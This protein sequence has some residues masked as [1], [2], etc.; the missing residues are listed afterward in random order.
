MPY[1]IS[2]VVYCRHGAHLTLVG[3]NELY[4]RNEPVK[5]RDDPLGYPALLNVSQIEAPGRSRAWICTQYLH[6]DP[7]LPWDAQLA[8]LLNHTWNGAF[9]L[10][11]E[12]HEGASWYGVSKGVHSDL[13]P[14]DRWERATANSETFALHVPWKPAP[15]NVGQ[16]MCAM[17][18]EC[19][20]SLGRGIPTRRRSKAKLGNLVSR[21]VNFLQQRKP[22]PDS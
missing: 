20:Q 1:A 7:G 9:N 15:L 19:Q 3:Y 4:F 12:H 6:V 22:K 11:S 18:E 5:T 13:H 2:F 16:T 8:A 17:V 14:I 21:F 10:S